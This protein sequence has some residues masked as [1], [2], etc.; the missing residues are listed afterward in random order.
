M[1]CH[2]I[3]QLG[4]ALDNV[5]GVKAG[6]YNQLLVLAKV[7]W[8]GGIITCVQSALIIS[9]RGGV[10]HRTSVNLHTHSPFCPS[11]HTD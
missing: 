10:E 4:S 6:L 1:P 11:T 8:E 3:C 2:I 7:R 9:Q 5:D